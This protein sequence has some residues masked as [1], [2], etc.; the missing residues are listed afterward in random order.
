MLVGS[1]MREELKRL[2]VETLNLD[3][4]TPD[5]IDDDAP[6]FG[7]ELGLDSVDALE[8]V[9]AIEKAYGV[10]IADTD[11]VRVAFQSVAS[12]SEYIRRLRDESHSQG[13]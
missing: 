13:G 3:G 7:E 10:K 6:L 4:I 2:I 5:M 9:V 8:L 1:A 12:L 11:E